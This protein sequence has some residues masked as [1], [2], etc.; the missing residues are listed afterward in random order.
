MTRKHTP[1]LTYVECLHI[2]TVTSEHTTHRILLSE[3]ISRVNQTVYMQMC[4]DERKQT[5]SGRLL[6]SVRP[7]P[8]TL[9]SFL[10]CSRKH[11]VC[12]TIGSRSFIFYDILQLDAGNPG[13]HDHQQRIYQN[14]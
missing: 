6:C 13:E 12:R 4:H 10:R 2:V 5:T 1:C 8:K 3:L 11:N 9:G 14:L 7:R